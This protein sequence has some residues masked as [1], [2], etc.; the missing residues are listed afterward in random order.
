MSIEKLAVFVNPWFVST[1]PV[2]YRWIELLYRIFI[3]DN[4]KLF[5]IREG[6]AQEGPHVVKS[7]QFGCCCAFRLIFWQAKRKMIFFLLE[8]LIYKNSCGLHLEI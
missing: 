4:K 1:K 8:T 2:Y 6:T 3:V 7:R 5:E